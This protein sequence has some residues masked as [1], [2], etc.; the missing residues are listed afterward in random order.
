MSHIPVLLHETVDALECKPGAFIIDGT[1]NGGGHAREIIS[2]IMPGGLFL[3]IDWDGTVLE[4]T[5]GELKEQFAQHA[6]GLHFAASNYRDAS[7]AI[8]AESLPQADGMMVDLGFSSWQIDN[9]DRGFSFQ[10]EGIL[11]MR[12][13]TSSGTPAYEIVNRYSQEDLA[14]I[15]WRYGEERQS[16]RIAKAIVESR[17]R[18]PIVRTTQL[19]DCI[20]RVMP[21][22]GKIH[23]AT[24]TFQALRI[25]VN[26]ELEN[27]EALLP[28]AQACLKKGGRLA[29]ISFHSLEDRIIK[30]AFRAAA[31]EGKGRIITKKPI[32]PTRE[33]CIANPRSRSA[34][35]RVLEII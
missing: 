8:A 6:Q 35:L 33:E 7:K 19:A 20:A 12:Y 23:P 26:H 17:V 9:P 28:T 10:K 16:R 30:N 25:Y 1:M 15:I 32:A 14:D 4:K 24:R 5:S 34:K 18:V 27:V 29:V 13:D 11:D 22:R 3:G 31:A 21:R 2:R